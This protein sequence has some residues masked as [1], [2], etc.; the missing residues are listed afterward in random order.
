MA[1][2]PVYSVFAV[3]ASGHELFVQEFA[4]LS[5]A[6]ECAV[7]HNSLNDGYD[8]R[9]AETGSW[10]DTSELYSEYVAMITG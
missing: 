4:Q 3:S 6:E 7:L 9:V 1:L 5:D 8:H 2:R 10:D